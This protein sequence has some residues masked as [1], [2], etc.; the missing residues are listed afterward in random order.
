MRVAGPAVLPKYSG[1]RSPR[2]SL[3]SSPKPVLRASGIPSAGRYASESTP[4]LTR[5]ST[6]TPS[7]RPAAS[8]TRGA[9]PSESRAVASVVRSPSLSGRGGGAGGS[10]SRR[11]TVAPW[12]PKSSRTAS[13]TP[14]TAAKTPPARTSSAAR[15][16]ANDLLKMIR[17]RRGLA[18][19][20]TRSLTDWVRSG[21]G[22][23][24]SSRPSCVS[25]RSSSFTPRPPPELHP[26]PV[27]PARDARLHRPARA[28]ERRRRLL[29]R[30]VEQVAA[31]DRLSG[32]VRQPLDRRQQ[33][34]APLGVE[35]RRLGRRDRVVRAALLGHAQHEPRSAAGGPEAV[36]R[37]IRDDREQPGPERSALAEA[38]ERRVRL[39]E[40][41][42]RGLLGVRLG[43][44]DHPRGPE[45]DR[46]MHSHDLLVGI[47]L[48][49]LRAH[50]ELRL[51]W[52]PVLHRA[53]TT[54]QS[55]RRF[56][57]ADS[58]GIREGCGKPQPLPG[59]P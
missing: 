30:Q 15:A 47:R 35:E 55:A 27:E 33:P 54:T 10:C 36:A 24:S 58:T 11:S 59:R 22:G 51:L 46:L 43:A 16:I 13:R 17:L 38:A 52:W 14:G 56:R 48:A 19:E 5:S 9:K 26:Q 34:L 39:D 2:N 4:P 6:N 29:L 50:Y 57:V 53:P 18:G 12:R 28:V 31:D 3:T 44:R 37:L 25:W 42:L 7:G 49:A 8:G 32:G 41:V 23:Q 20:G 40:R 1:S 21:I 45:R